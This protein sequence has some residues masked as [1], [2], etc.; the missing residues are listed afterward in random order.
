MEYTKHI[1]NKTVNPK[2]I[3]SKELAVWIKYRTLL[4]ISTKKQTR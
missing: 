3:R 1:E 2:F 4:E